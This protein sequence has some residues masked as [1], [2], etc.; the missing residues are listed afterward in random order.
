MNVILFLINIVKS[1]INII[2]KG[3]RGEREQGKVKISIFPLLFL[4]LSLVLLTACTAS[5]FRTKAIYEATENGYRMEIV[6]WG[7]L[8]NQQLAYTGEYDVTFSPIIKGDVE[9]FSVRYPNK[10]DP[11]YPVTTWVGENG[12]Q[13]YEGMYL[14]SILEEVLAAAGYSTFNEGEMEETY[15]AIEGIASGPSTTIRDDAKYLN[16]VEVV[17]NYKGE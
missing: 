14:D 9:K 2:K 12:Q 13:T 1:L 15:F 7:E 11:N 3:S 16:V 5:S 10:D 4:S 17:E 8:D 6:A